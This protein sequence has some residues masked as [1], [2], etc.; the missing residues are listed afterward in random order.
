MFAEKQ[1]AG[2]HG[3]CGAGFADVFDVHAAA[4]N[5]FSRLAFPKDRGRRRAA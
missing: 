4:F 2:S 5:I 1:I 3:P